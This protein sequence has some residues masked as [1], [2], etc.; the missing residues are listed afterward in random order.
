MKKIITLIII[1][2][3]ITGYYIID[4]NKKNR[5]IQTIITEDN[6]EPETIK[7]YGILCNK[8]ENI[9]TILKNNETF[10]EIN[11]ENIENINLGQA[12]ILNYN[13][14]NELINIE[15]LKKDSKEYYNIFENEGIFKNYYKK[16]FEKLNT[17]TL[18]EKIGQLLFVRIP[19]ENQITPIKD[20][21]IGGYILFGRDT[22]NET[23]E[24]LKNK[25]KNYQNNSKIP[26]LIATDEEGGT[27][28]RISS[29]PNLRQTPFK[30]PQ[31]IYKEGGIE[32]IKNN[33]TEISTLL[34]ELE[35]NVNF[36]PV[37]DISNNPNDFI[38]DRSIGLDTTGTSEYIKNIIIQSKNYNVSYTMKHFP[39]YGNNEDTHTG[40]AFDNRSIESI[41]E[42]DLMP[43]KS[44]IENNAEAIM[45][46]H[47]IINNLDD[48]PASLSY[49]VH[50]LARKDLNF[51][52]I[53]MTDDMDMSAITQYTDSP[54]IEAILAGNDMI[55]LS[56]YETASNTILNA[57]NNNELSEDIIN[58]AAF[59]VLSWKYY[60]GLIK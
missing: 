15:P 29:N 49:K 11:I 59:K 32:A 30:S 8:T 56:D 27:V 60:K 20:Y 44:G 55:Q 1:L 5:T 10:E 23:K 52:G 7:K 31:E 4:K 35:I 3:I 57:I 50:N 9:I 43:F 6:Q 46:S 51:N 22:K 41:K 26:L 18:K 39:G 19:D 48:T 58:H 53:L 16:A 45:V 54:Y 38:Y 33:I 13:E 2:L 47:N 36:A 24:S 34:D 14:N 37:A 17:M 42:N 12:I 28:V 40:I 25:I 21:N